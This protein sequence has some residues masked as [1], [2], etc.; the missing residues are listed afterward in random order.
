MGKTC[1]R[2]FLGLEEEFN[3]YKGQQEWECIP[4]TE[5][6]ECIKEK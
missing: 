3:K 1:V 6:V 2:A 4:E 5:E